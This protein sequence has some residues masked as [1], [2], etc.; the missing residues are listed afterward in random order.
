MSSSS[1]LL[2]LIF[3]FHFLSAD[4]LAQ[5]FIESKPETFKKLNIS[6]NYRFHLQYR[7]FNNPYILDA[8]SLDTSILATNTFFIGDATQLP[9]LTLNISANPSENVSFGTDL[10]FWNQQTGQFDYFRGLNL[11]INLYGS[12]KTSFGN[13]NLRTGGIHWL[14]L[15]RFTM[16]AA[17]GFNRYSLFVRNP[18]DPQYAVFSQRYSDYYNRGSVQQ[19]VRWGNKAFQGI[20]VDAGELPL[21]LNATFLYGKAETSGAQFKEVDNTNYQQS[22]QF[23]NTQFYSSLLPSYVIGARLT[24]TLDKGDISLNTINGYS[25]LDSLAVNMNQYEFHSLDYMLQS[26]NVTFIGEVGVSKFNDL[27]YDYG[28]VAKLKTKKSLTYLPLDLEWF[29]IGKDVYNNNSEIIN[30][31]VDDALPD[32]PTQGGVLAQTGSAILGVGNLANNRTG[33]SINTEYNF[34]SLKINFGQTISKELER[35]N[36]QLTYGRKINSVTFSEF[37]RWSYPTLAGPYNRIS[38]YFRGVYETVNLDNVRGGEIKDDKYFNSL[39]LQAKYKYSFKKYNSFFFYLG[40]FNSVQTKFSPMVV[41]TEDAYIRQYVHEFENYLTM[42]PRTII[43]S[44]L[45]FERIIGNYETDINDDTFMPRNQTTIGVGLGVD[46]SLSKNTA[47]YL[48]HRYFSFE[49]RN[50][51]LDNNNG[52]ETT[53]ELKVSF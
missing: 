24:K 7:H 49:D 35:V 44:Y 6:G 37:Y 8:S 14:R 3:I 52:H 50:F 30:T 2:F 10:T 45:G 9:E 20:A 11:G 17:E 18:W 33:I 15:S 12:F 1:R 5:S 43:T 46:Y 19:D 21:G 48:R 26:K 41:F 42:S 32:D 23:L 31:S 4:I 36:S 53:L 47:L 51:V 39:E 29:Y 28:L 27:D 13:F 34:N 16:K 38:K 22:V 40:A 25:Y